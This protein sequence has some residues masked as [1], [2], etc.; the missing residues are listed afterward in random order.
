[1][2]QSSESAIISVAS[3]VLASVFL[4][5]LLA[6]LL[7][8][9]N[10]N[11]CC[12]SIPKNKQNKDIQHEALVTARYDDN[13]TLSNHLYFTAMSILVISSH[14][15]ES[16]LDPEDLLIH[17]DLDK[18]LEEHRWKW[19]DD[20]LGVVPLCLAMLKNC[21]LMSERLAQQ[22]MASSDPLKFAELAV[23]RKQTIVLKI[24]CSSLI[25]FYF[26]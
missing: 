8:C 25:E 17:P 2:Q 11:F 13:R 23:V 18:L 5:A 26:L 15:L 4:A 24:D 7:I 16:C 9:R 21:H 20:A 22:A 1:M 14:K 12:L 6:L 10:C 19:I 3:V